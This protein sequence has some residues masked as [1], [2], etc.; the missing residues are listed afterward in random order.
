MKGRRG[1]L[2]HPFGRGGGGAG[3]TKSGIY[4]IALEKYCSPA[5]PVQCSSRKVASKFC[6]PA[7]A[8]DI[9]DEAAPTNKQSPE[10][11]LW[12]Q[13]VVQAPNRR[14]HSVLLGA[15]LS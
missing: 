2:R 6:I 14:G 4:E 13:F 11:G 12:A 1:L 5:L 8:S 15:Q 7:A 3:A 9:I 10:M